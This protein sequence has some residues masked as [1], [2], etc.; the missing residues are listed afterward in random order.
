[1]R[2]LVTGSRD[3]PDRNKVYQELEMVLGAQKEITVVHGHCP[4]G[5][6]RYADDWALD[7]QLIYGDETDL[8]RVE[9]YPADWN[10]PLKKRAGFARNAEM[11]ALGAD[12][13]LAFI[14]NESKGAT[15]CAELA[16]KAGIPTQIFR[17]NTV[18]DIVRRVENDLTFDDARIIFRNF[19][20]EERLYNNAGQRN[21]SV[22]LDEET[23]LKLMEQGWNVKAGKEPTDEGGERLYHLKVNVKMNGKNPPK[24]FV[25]T[26]SKNSRTP[27]DEDTAMV[28]DYA[29]FDRVDLLIRPYNW[30]VQGKQGVSAY[31]KTG[32]FVLHEDEIELRYAHIP[33]EGESPAIENVID[34]QVES[35]TD[36]MNDDDPRAI[37]K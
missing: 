4:K 21:F 27:L 11:V 23:A 2:V 16:E 33:L 20:G 5:A 6:D 15:H 26:K 12:L 7:L 34:A 17:S 31:L 14:H 1:M 13:C 24:L 35:D 18:P 25:I 28:L 10:G 32:A 9:R 37:E 30:D 29:E 8:V 19:A 3:W 36:W 22:A